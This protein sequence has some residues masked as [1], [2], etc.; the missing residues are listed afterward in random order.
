MKRSQMALAILAIIVLAVGSFALGYFIQSNANGTQ[1]GSVTF[2]KPSESVGEKASH[3]RTQAQ[4]KQERFS[5]KELSDPTRFDSRIARTAALVESLQTSNAN[6]LL[7][8][9]SQSKSMQAGAWQTEVQNAIIQRMA[10][11]DPIEA[12]AEAGT[13]SESRQQTLVPIVYREWSVSNLD[14]AVDH[15]Q[16]FDDDLKKR[17]I[18]SIV[19]SRTDLSTDQIRTI[20]RNLAHESIAIKLLREQSGLET[21]KDPQRELKKFLDQNARSLDDLNEPQSEMFRQLVIATVLR[22]GVEAF[23]EIEKSLPMS[24]TQ[25]QGFLFSVGLD[26][27]QINPELALQLAVKTGSVGFGGFA[28]FTVRKWANSDAVSALSAVSALEGPSAR[29]MLQSRIMESWA[30]KDPNELLDAS[31][32]MPENLRVIGQEKALI[33]MARSSPQEAL[34]F[35]GEIAD[36]DVRDRIAN[37]I[38]SSWARLDSD[39]ALRWIEDDET[40]SSKNDLR[41]AVVTSLA[42]INPQLAIATAL[43]LPPDEFG[44]GLE[45]SAIRTLIHQDLDMAIELLPLARDNTTKSDAYDTV[46]STLLYSQN[47]FRQAFD[48]FIHLVE[49]V[50]TPEKGLFTLAWNRP[51]DLFQSLNE[52][53]TEELKKQAAR[54]LLSD[55]ERSDVLTDEQ[56]E[57]LRKLDDSP[58]IERTPEMEEAF[59][60]LLE[61]FD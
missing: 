57:H 17:V 19:L 43:E 33:V 1:D 20:A 30:V 55:H 4:D 32:T 45:A 28:D 23:V 3:D 6:Q 12:L 38:A 46:M 37:S 60:M 61:A 47:D 5:I 53:P 21:I 13:F 27:G 24:H 25:K 36:K 58:R 49:D 10:M 8:L 11:L 35:M 14:Q 7:K 41:E 29:Q 52:L 16:D 34:S 26:L 42:R 54:Y 18:E 56:L 51:A 50:G 2:S 48:L 9:L 31:R 15:A 39:A 22:E 40:L 44:R 59:E